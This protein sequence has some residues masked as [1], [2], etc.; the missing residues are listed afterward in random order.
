VLKRVWYGVVKCVLQG[1]PCVDDVL[2]RVCVGGSREKRQS[3][4]EKER[5]REREGDRERG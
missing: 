1:L 4:I 3:E 2:W 5:E